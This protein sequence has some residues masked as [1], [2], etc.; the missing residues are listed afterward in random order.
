MSSQ[1][2]EHDITE[3]KWLGRA[4]STATYMRNQCTSRHRIE[5]VDMQQH[6]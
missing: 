6:R 2:A 4:A 5:T 3:S 1:E